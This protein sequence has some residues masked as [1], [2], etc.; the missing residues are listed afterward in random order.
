MKHPQLVILTEQSDKSADMVCQ[1]L[2]HWGCEFLRIN[3]D[4]SINPMVK[5]SFEK[6]GNTST[7]RLHGEEFQLNEIKTTWFRRGYVKCM[8][9]GNVPNLQSRTNKSIERHLE[10]EGK[11]LEEFLYF[12]LGQSQGINHPNCYNYNKLI[13]LFEAQKI[14]FHIPPTLL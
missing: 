11:T 10:N 2:Y 9:V 3:E 8:S 5:V 4:S 1:W 14:G 7:L 6:E 12:I 13:A